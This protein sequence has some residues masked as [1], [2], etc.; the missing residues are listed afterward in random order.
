MIGNERL[1]HWDGDGLML[2]WG[3]GCVVLSRLLIG[4]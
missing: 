3:I 4:E 1:G 2:M